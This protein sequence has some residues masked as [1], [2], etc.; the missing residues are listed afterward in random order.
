MT[1]T[2]PDLLRMYHTMLLIRRF[3]EKATEFFLNGQD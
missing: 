1:L 3:E 2:Q